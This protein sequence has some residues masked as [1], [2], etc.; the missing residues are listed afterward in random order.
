MS[1]LL[2]SEEGVDWFERGGVGSAAVMLALDTT[3]FDVCRAGGAYGGLKQ[4]QS[5]GCSSCKGESW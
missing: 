4:Q 3:L 5:L 1:P 2:L